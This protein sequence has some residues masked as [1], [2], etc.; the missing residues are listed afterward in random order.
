MSLPPL[1]RNTLRILKA[2]T[3]EEMRLEQIKKCVSDIYQAIRSQA[4]FTTDTSY[5][6]T[7]PPFPIS[8]ITRLP[9]PEFHR[10]NMNDILRELK[11]LFP[12][13]TVEFTMLMRGNDD[14]YYPIPK[15]DDNILKFINTAQTQTIDCI[16]VDWS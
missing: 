10:D 6:Y 7:V 11:I 4:K 16:L 9:L 13:C 5:K 1:S 15:M 3:D 12:D 2:Q 14:K 8:K